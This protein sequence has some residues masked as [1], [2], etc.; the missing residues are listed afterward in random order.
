MSEIAG[1]LSDMRALLARLE[2][3]IAPRQFGPEFRE[4]MRSIWLNLEA[5]GSITIELRHAHTNLAE[6][7][8]TLDLHPKSSSIDGVRDRFSVYEVVA[9]RSQQP[10]SD[11]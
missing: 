7:L 6:A 10:T 5:A 8:D 1:H 2:K 9:A 3:D 4:H 11:R